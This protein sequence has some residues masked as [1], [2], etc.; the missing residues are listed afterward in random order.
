MTESEK[1]SCPKCQVMVAVPVEAF[2]VT[3]QCGAALDVVHDSWF[4]GED[5]HPM[6]YLELSTEKP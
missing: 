6:A 3:C 2:T 4:D 5:D 1:L